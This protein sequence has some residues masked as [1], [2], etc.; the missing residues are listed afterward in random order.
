MIHQRGVVI[1][2]RQEVNHKT[3]SEQNKESLEMRFAWKNMRGLQVAASSRGNLAFAGSP[4][5]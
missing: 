4:N 1:I 2:H 5:K 3:V